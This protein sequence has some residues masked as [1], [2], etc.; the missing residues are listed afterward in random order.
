MTIYLQ[1]SVASQEIPLGIF[2]DSTD[3]NTEES[4]LTIANTDIKIWK[5]GATTLASKNSGGATYI[6][7]G[8][9]YAVLD[10]TDTDT[11]G[12][13]VIF[14]HV[15]GAL[16][17]KLECLVVT[18]AAYTFMTANTIAADLTTIDNFLDTEVAAILSDTNAILTD[19]NDIQTRLPAA[20]VAGRIDASVGAMAANVMTAAAADPGLTTELQA[21][22]AT[23]AALTTIDDF[24]DT[25]IAA[26]LSDTNAILIDT[27]EIGLAGAGLTALAT[28]ASVN[29]ID[30]L[31][32]TEIAALTTAVADLPTNAELAT[33]LGTAD[34]AV[35]AALV[36]IDDFLD[37]EIA[38]I[39]AKT[40]LIPAS[41]ATS[42]E[43][44]AVLTTAMTE[45]Y[46]TDGGTMT[47]AQAL[48]LLRGH[49]GDFAISG[50][51]LTVKKVDGS[52]A[53]ATFTLD[54]AVTPTSITRAT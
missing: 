10:A 2:V 52:T 50:T 31:L 41:P 44:A 1:Q 20:L 43:V 30:D 6:S 29:T 25:E 8:V 26:I 28:Q 45:A 33:A 34:D 19:T 42:A 38:A 13:M 7:N 27:A 51:T 24:L 17:V 39:K 54:S 21:G 36:T 16:A 40:D 48:Y 5:T 15:S 14:V 9:Y 49:L 22:L 35:L 23:A 46:P 37:T 32:D 53:A 18:A 3:G 47:I 4:G 11:L 12:P